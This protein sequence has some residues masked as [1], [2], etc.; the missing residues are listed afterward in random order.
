MSLYILLKIVS[1]FPLARLTLKQASMCYRRAVQESQTCIAVSF[2]CIFKIPLDHLY[3][4]L[5]GTTV[6]FTFHPSS[7]L[8]CT[9]ILTKKVILMC[10]KEKNYVVQHLRYTPWHCTRLDDLVFIL[11]IICV[12]LPSHRLSSVLPVQGVTK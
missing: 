6:N 9:K 2:M 1:G 12:L 5:L 8:P 10:V 4:P 11:I 3:S 7:V